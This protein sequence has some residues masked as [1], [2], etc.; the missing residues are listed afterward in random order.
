MPR[1]RFPVAPAY[2]RLARSYD[3][4]LGRENFAHTRRIFESLVR[5]HR[6]AFRTAADVG[7]G[8]GLFA[9]YLA[10]GWGVPVFAV[11]RSRE[12]LEVARGNCP[13]GG[14]CLLQQDIRCLGL[15]YPVDLITANFDVVNHLP[16]VADLRRTFRRVGANLAP[17]GHFIFD[18]VTN[19][20][21]LGGP[22][23][24]VR[25]LRGSGH[26]LIQ[27]IHWDPRRQRLLGFVV[28]LRPGDGGPASIERY[29]ERGY[30]P[31][32]MARALRDAGLVVR[33][34]H[35]AAT[36][37]PARRCPARIVV[38]AQRPSVTLDEP[39]V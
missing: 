33:G 11:D 12:M 30:P 8:T 3:A 14:V 15:P 18:A 32:L 39:R 23:V 4:A 31:A 7:C 24:Y 38:V 10:E 36:L 27:Q 17:G 2:S 5:C 20:R 34:V 9:R 37:R 1:A 29:V 16:E 19:C 22:S 6:V 21:P 35:D 28:H 13:S 26:D 25:R